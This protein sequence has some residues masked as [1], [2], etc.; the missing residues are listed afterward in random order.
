MPAEADLIYK[1]RATI[2]DEMAVDLLAR[3]PDINLS[4]DTLARIILEVMSGGIEGLYLAN[5]LLH[6]DMFVQTAQ[7]TALARFG[8]QYGLEIKVGTGSTGLVRFSGAGGTFIPTG[9][10]VASDDGAGTILSYLTSEDGTLPTPGSPTAPTLADGGAGAMAVGTYEYVVTFLTPGGETTIGAVSATIAQAAS[11]RVSL[12]AI[13][14]GGAGT[15]SRKIYRRVNGGAFGLVTTIADNSTTTYSDNNAATGAAPPDLSTAESVILAAESEDVGTIYNAAPSTITTL[16]SVPDGVTDVTNTTAF[17]GGTDEED[18]E[19]FRAALLEVLRNPGSGSPGDIKAWAERIDGVETASVFTND[20]LGTPTNGH[21]TVRISGPDGTV[22]DTDVEDAVLADLEERGL[23]NITFHVGT[24]TPVA[25]NVTV[26]I[27]EASGY[28]LGDITPNVQSAI[29]DYINS[30]PV[31]GTLT[32]A[33]I[34]AAAWAVTG[35]ADAVVSVPAS[36]TTYTA[37]QKPTPG[38]ITVT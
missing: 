13:P 27:T 38:T 19:E 3:I 34:T 28:T 26:N 6:D 15:T 33:G 2:Y 30:V 18:P 16:I 12:S 4:V 36:S 25:V 31:A 10:E 37:V 14:I 1:D 32:V 11:H 7:T 35:V 5:Q 8:D 29:S 21:T 23:A 24:F 9:S 17:S 22:P 20:N